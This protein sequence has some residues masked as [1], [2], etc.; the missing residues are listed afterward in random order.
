MRKSEEK[1]RNWDREK[2]NVGIRIRKCRSEPLRMNWKKIKKVM[3]RISKKGEKEER[4][5]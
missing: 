1:T 3:L 5:N 2:S 4:R